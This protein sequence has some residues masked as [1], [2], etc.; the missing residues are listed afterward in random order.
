MET[1]PRLVVFSTLFP[2]SAQPTAG[3]FIRER[4]FRVA[5]ELPVV[6]VAPK[7]WFPL[8]GLIRLFRPGFRPSAPR[9]ECQQG[10]DVYQPRFLSIPGLAKSLDGI[11]MAL[12][13]YWPMK[14]LRA[15]FGFNIIDS[16]FGYPEG[17]AAVQLG[18]WLKCPVTL[19]LRG[20]EVRHARDKALR[21]LLIKALTGADR[22][23]TVSDSLRR[24]ALELGVAPGRAQV[25]ANG[26]DADKFYPADRA[27]MR[28]KFNLPA[29]ARVLITVGGLVERKGFHRVIEL[30]PALL[31]QFPDL[32]YL[33]VGGASAEGDWGPRLREQ[34]D[35]LGLAER[36]HF[37]GT[38]PP[39]ALREPLSAA[40]V[41]VLSTRNEGWA[42]VLLEAMACGLPVVTTDVGGNAEVVA[43]PEL[44]MVVPFDDAP[45]L[46][47]ALAQALQQQWDHD[48]IVNYAR[49]NGWGQ[50]IDLLC[51]IFAE[52]AKQ[53]AMSGRELPQAGGAD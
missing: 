4:M 35:T 47:Q 43:Q 42:N 39:E 24:L 21:P 2:G 29:G 40:D 28:A 27:A 50:R 52:L 51:G 33:I 20:T 19:T 10:V 48:A 5:N 8:Q 12:S 46:Q 34:V 16:H 38:I 37:L 44:G 9:H 30:M 13:L 32:H 7:P 41:F 31:R 14:R 3:L 25:V 53:G 45:A 36:V 1:S 23:I 22:V 18:R 17:Y 26:V 11:L 6:V 15:R 49:D